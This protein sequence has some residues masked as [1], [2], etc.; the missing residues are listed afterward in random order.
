MHPVSLIEQGQVRNLLI[1][2]GRERG[3]LARRGWRRGL[4]RSAGRLRGEETVGVRKGTFVAWGHIR[5][6]VEARGGLRE[7][8][9]VRLELVEES[10]L[11][12]CC[13]IGRSTD[14]VRKGRREVK[15]RWLMLYSLLAWFKQL[16]D[17]VLDDVVV[18]LDAQCSDLAQKE[19]VPFLLWLLG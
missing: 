1:L 19:R 9:G 11:T 18:A 4:E 15:R 17:P 2:R 5:G 3:R 10:S 14:L 16:V 12:G 7:R 8:R 13:D 6:R